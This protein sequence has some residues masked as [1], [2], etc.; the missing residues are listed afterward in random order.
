M[1]RS[2]A[3]AFCVVLM[4]SLFCGSAKATTYSSDYLD[5]YD[6]SLSTGSRSGQL[7]L[8]FQA[9]SCGTMKSVGISSITVYTNDGS[10]VKTINGST[11]NGLLASQTFYHAG[12]YTISVTPGQEY[13]LRLTFVARDS[14]SGDSKFYTTNT[15]MAAR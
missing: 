10:Y 1:K 9:Y 7:A 14:Y 13:Y 11:S 2:F 4:L 8:D 6:A 5:T 15:A 3:L 12:T